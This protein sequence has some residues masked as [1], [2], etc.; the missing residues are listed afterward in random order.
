MK[1]NRELKQQHRAARQAH[2]ES[3]SNQAI[4]PINLTVIDC[5]CVIHGTGYDWQ[6]VERLYNMLSRYLPNGIRFH[7]YTEHD[8]SVPPHMIKHIL[9]DWG[10]SGPKKSWWYK[11]QLFNT[12]HFSGQLLYFDLDV[13]ITS[14][15]EWITKLSAD[16]FWCIRD[17]RYLQ[18]P[19][20]QSMN[21]SVMW[22]DVAK[23][24]WV[25]DKFNE[26]PVTKVVQSFPGDQDFLHHTINHFQRRFFDDC[27]FQS[28]R[29]QC[30]D[31]GYNFKRRQHYQP[32]S[33]I[34]ISPD[35]SVVVFHGRP[36]PHQI[37]DQIIQNLWQ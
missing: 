1:T 11:M 28:Y 37:Q 19:M 23:F 21:S 29:W 10:I 36:K 5:A 33:G 22:F 34:T 30:L 12:K 4:L 14:S 6:Y 7:V 13:I 2:R 24:N 27:K 16:Y 32:G 20:I 18:N 26:T 15:L 35:T 8:R 9:D 17:F 25:W 3:K 31:G